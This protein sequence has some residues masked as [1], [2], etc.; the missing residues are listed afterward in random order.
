MYSTQGTEQNGLWGV[1]SFFPTP[2]TVTQ[3]MLSKIEV[4]NTDQIL[5]PSAG[6]GDMAQVIRGKFPNNRIWTAEKDMTLAIQ[7]L[8][9]GFKV[10]TQ[11][12][13]TLKD[14]FEVIVMNPPFSNNYQDVDHICHAWRCLKEGG[15]LVALCHEYTAYS[16]STNPYYKPTVFNQWTDRMGIHKE[17][18]PEGS[19]L[20]SEYPTNVRVALLWGTKVCMK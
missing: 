1:P 6:K 20:N 9:K 3:Y 12:F 2:V 5:E 13:L 7:L 15:R 17:L 10:L 8:V 11:D 18:L 19:F 4:K 14:Q 16:P